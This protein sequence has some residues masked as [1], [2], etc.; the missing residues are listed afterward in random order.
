[1]ANIKSQE[2]RIEI[3]ERNNAR[4]AA[5]KSEVRTSIKKVE[6]LIAEGK[7]AEATAALNETISLLDKAAQDGI[8]TKNSVSR[9][10]AHL[11]HAVSALA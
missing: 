7:K 4:A 8:L 6:A 5:R 11:Q 10:K 2:K 9:K 3:G 1:M